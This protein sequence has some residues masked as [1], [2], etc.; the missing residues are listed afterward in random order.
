MLDA[1]PV[2]QIIICVASGIIASLFRPV[3]RPL[4][5]LL[6]SLLGV[7]AAYRGSTLGFILVNGIVFLFALTLSRAANVSARDGKFRWRWSLIA[8]LALIGAFLVGRW[9][10][11]ESRGVSIA[12]VQWSLF[13]LDMWMLIRLVTFLWEF[14]SGRIAQPSLIN[15]AVWA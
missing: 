6:L 8:L 5:F 3:R 7:A 11:L 13:S 1:I 15:F 9:L 14:G 4:F 12:G 10:E 2:A